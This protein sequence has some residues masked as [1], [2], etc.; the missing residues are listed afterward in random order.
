MKKSLNVLS[1]IV[2]RK[3]YVE[4]ISIFC[5]SK[6]CWI[7]YVETTSIF[8]PLKLRRTKYVKT[9]SIFCPSKLRRRKY[10]ETTSIFRPS[11]LHPKSTSIW[12]GNSLIF[13]LRRID[14]ISPSNWRPFDV[15]CSLGNTLERF[16]LY[17]LLI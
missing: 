10:V 14:I 8:H 13:S 6:L 3:K 16:S 2:C 4:T 17:P 5:S 1:K 9:T 15:V 12:R 11:K 7:K